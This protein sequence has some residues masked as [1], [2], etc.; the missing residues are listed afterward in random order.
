MAARS[1]NFS[2][3][4]AIVAVALACGL[5][6]A[7]APAAHADG[8]VDP[9]PIGPDQF[10]T[11]QVNGAGVDAAIQMACFGPLTPGETG[12]PLAGQTVDVLPAAASGTA[13]V[14]YTGAAA[15][16]VVVSF[17]VAS[18]TAPVTL[19]FYAVKAPIPTSLVLPCA[20]TGTV[21]FTPAPSSPTAHP[22]TLAVRYVPQP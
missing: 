9:A 18:V 22:A 5:A 8:V 19:D 17:G 16:S 3:C 11:G 4:R 1:I 14:G 21:V 6:A 10:F 2:A 20:G 12:H 7:V 15:T 13:D